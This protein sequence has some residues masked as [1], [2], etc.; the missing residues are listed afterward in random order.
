ML[1]FVYLVYRYTLPLFRFAR[2]AL[3]H[4]TSKFFRE[5]LD[6]QLAGCTTGESMEMVDY[7]AINPRVGKCVILLG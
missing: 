1:L 2:L 6:V 3:P 7:F 4:V 5:C